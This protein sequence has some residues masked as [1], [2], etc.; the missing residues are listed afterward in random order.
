MFKRFLLLAL[1]LLLLLGGGYLILN[2]ETVLSVW[3][4]MY[5]PKDTR[6]I[7]ALV[8]R[9][10]GNPKLKLPK[11]LVYKSIRES[12]QLRYYDTI[13]TDEK[14]HI[15]I[16]F[17]NG[18]VL[19]LEPNSLLVLE[20]SQDGESGGV[21]I[22]FLQG[23]FKVIQEGKSGKVFLAKDSQVLDTAGRLPP[24]ESIIIAPELDQLE[25]EIEVAT[26]TPTPPP[27]QIARPRPTP[28]PT[29]VRAKESL[30]DDY[31]A[32][33]VKKQKPFLN[34]CYAQH[35]R[36]NPNASGKMSISFT[37]EPTGGVTSVRILRSSIADPRLQKCTLTV[38]ERMQFK[39][40]DGD[41]IVVN[42]PINFE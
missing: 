16:A 31:I 22:S 21:V 37:V 30:P 42:Y 40:F 11:R 4:E 3:D 35:L 6:E 2:Y 25:P 17:T 29:P 12:Q 26:P 15:T 5:G 9:T 33:I 23:N 38:L 32:S 39:T 14:S 28:K 1:A 13:Q 19:D 18:L 24:K 41:P 7:V 27:V 34:R 36:L 8:T 20:K 10:D